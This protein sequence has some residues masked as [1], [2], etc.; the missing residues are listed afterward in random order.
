[1][2]KSSIS[3]P[4]VPWQ[5]FGLAAIAGAAVIAAVVFWQSP[6]KDDVQENTAAPK[7]SAVFGPG[8]LSGTDDHG[9]LAHQE[10]LT[11]QQAEVPGRLNVEPNQ[12]LVID[13]GLLEVINYFLLEQTGAD[14]VGALQSY[15]KS[16]LP[17]PAYAQASSIVERYMAYMKA[18]DNLLQGQNLGAEDV[19]SRA[20]NIERLRTWRE[21]RDR[22]RMDT[23]GENVVRAWY[24][25]DDAVLNE[26][27]QELQLRNQLS[28]AADGGKPPRDAEDDAM[29]EQ[30]MQRILNRFT[31]SYTAQAKEKQLW[32]QHLATFRAAVA[33]INQQTNLSSLQRN[34]QIA[35]LL[36]KSF[37][38]EEERQHVRDLMP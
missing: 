26:I 23:L 13:P 34:H 17:P 5:R 19:A 12:Q 6:G 33:Q 1:M 29:H 4:D 11:T 2:P 21:Q 31:E 22:L 15:L 14:R 24:Q 20:H 27:F 35:E 32:S 25:N 9:S 36:E 10:E 38:N 8:V 30:D 3:K 28:T 16:K 7:T 18:H 37:P